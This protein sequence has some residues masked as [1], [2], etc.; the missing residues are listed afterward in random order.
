[1]SKLLIIG[2]GFDL[3][4][5]LASSYADFYEKRFSPSLI[6]Q[7]NH[8]KHYYYEVAEG[9][10]GYNFFNTISFDVSSPQLDNIS[11]KTNDI[12][13]SEADFQNITFWDLIFYFSKKDQNDYEWHNIENRIF[14]FLNKQND[15][16]FFDSFYQPDTPSIANLCSAIFFSYFNKERWNQFDSP[17]SFLLEE[18]NLLESRFEEYLINEIKLS[19]NY[20]NNSIKLI[21]QLFDIKESTHHKGH[22]DLLNFNYTEP[23]KKEDLNSF[24][25]AGIFSPSSN[26][27]YNN[28]HGKLSEKNIIFGID[29]KGFKTTDSQ[30]LFTKTYRQ[31]IG[32]YLISSKTTNLLKPNKHTSI[33]FYGHSLSS[34][35]YSYFQAIFD[36]YQIYSSNV[37]LIFYYSI[38]DLNRANE[39]KLDMVN[40][41][42]NLIE[43]YAST[44]DNYDHRENLISKLIIE[45]RLTIEE[46]NPQE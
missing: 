38:Y 37:N 10:N 39:I 43:S 3:Q 31:M 28:I 46:L 14:Y 24:S 30:Y 7:L 32:N 1:M 16:S 4:A 45:G 15:N 44:L 17:F 27:S 29:P 8:L 25:R 9:R 11:I 5:G 6:K 18:L 36:C 19:K 12:S 20:H 41:V 21:H 40:K 23:F 42:M 2:N 35:D 26:V 33:V 22:F 13:I 34:L